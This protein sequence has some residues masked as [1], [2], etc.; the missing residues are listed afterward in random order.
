MI[1]IPV[2]SF[3]KLKC[4]CTLD[5]CEPG[6]SDKIILANPKNAGTGRQFAYKMFCSFSKSGTKKAVE[7]L[8]ASIV[9]S[10]NE[11]ASKK[12]GEV[13]LMIAN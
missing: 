11:L 2:E 4:L 10:L 3:D 7:K 9:K 1:K 6:T 12:W 13:C 8:C 5:R